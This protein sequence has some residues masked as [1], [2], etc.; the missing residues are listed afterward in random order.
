MLRRSQ[1]PDQNPLTKTQILKVLYPSFEDKV[2]E[3]MKVRQQELLSKNK[4]WGKDSND[5]YSPYQAE[6]DIFRNLDKAAGYVQ[7]A[8]EEEK[9][10]E[11]KEGAKQISQKGAELN[12]DEM[13][14]EVV[15]AKPWTQD[16]S[17]QESH[18][19]KL[20]NGAAASF[21]KKHVDM[22]RL[23]QMLQV[24]PPDLFDVRQFP[25]LNGDQ[26]VFFGLLFQNLMHP[27]NAQRREACTNNVYV[28]VLDKVAADNYLCN[29]L[30]SNLRNEISGR[31][32]Q[33]LLA[34]Q[35]SMSSEIASL[36]Y[37]APDIYLAAAV[38]KCNGF[39]NGK[40]DMASVVRHMIKAAEPLP[41]AKD[42][43]IL[44]QMGMFH[45]VKI[46]ADKF[47]DYPDRFNLKAK[48]VFKLW[49]AIVR[50]R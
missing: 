24:V 20:M 7:K 33:I 23:A 9:K 4:K 36:F 5:A 41:C 48:R 29:M 47:K 16:Y 1:K 8:Q 32:S 3:I 37:G 30:K 15:G 38:L 18:I 46:Y 43:L 14:D 17:K 45:N 10:E 50:N 22:V 11:S 12:I 26:D 19:S 40:G 44:I 31:E 34:M 25:L 21:N 27:K 42:K 49:M 2:A 28:D 39:Y 13:V 35:Q 6:A